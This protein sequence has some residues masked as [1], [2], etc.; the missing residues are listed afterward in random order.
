MGKF[1]SVRDGRLAI[2]AAPYRF[3][4]ANIWYGAYLGASSGDRTRLRA[5]LDRLLAIGVTNLRVLGASELSPLKNSL[6]PAFRDRA[7][8][9]DEDLLVG[10]DFLLSEIATRGMHAVIYLGNFWE[11]SGGFATYLYWTNGGRYIDMNDPAHPWPE[12]PDFSSQFYASE[13]AVSLYRDY[14]SSLVSR[15]NT[16]TN[17]PYR[18]DPAI[19]SWQLANEPRPGGSA[20]SAAQNMQA[21]LRWIADTAR[22]IKSIDPNHLVSTGSEG[23]TGCA[24]SPQCVHDAHASADIDYLTD[25]ARVQSFDDDGG[26][27]GPRA[28]DC[29]GQS[30]RPRAE[31]DHIVHFHALLLCRPPSGSIVGRQQP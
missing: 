22:L 29:G 13:A 18:D 28:V 14:V 26:Q 31:D 24:E 23:L 30:R 8:P 5:E 15:I 25:A 4:G 3:V 16:I 17:T 9:Y 27:I 20:E 21:Y 6:A 10:L 1:V 7:P 19:M 11:W 12:F 2:G